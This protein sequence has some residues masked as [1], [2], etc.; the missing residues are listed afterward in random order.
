MA[1]LILALYHFY[2]TTGGIMLQTIA[3]IHSLSSTLVQKMNVVVSQTRHTMYLYS[4]RSIFI[5]LLL[6]VN[7]DGV[8]IFNSIFIPPPPSSSAGQQGWTLRH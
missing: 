2:S 1:R 6:L 3:S 8:L 7:K 5:L 4:T